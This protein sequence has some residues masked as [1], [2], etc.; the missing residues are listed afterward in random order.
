LRVYGD[1]AR[2]FAL[3]E[4]MAHHLSAAGLGSASEIFDGDAPFVPRG[5]IAQAWSVG[6]ILRAWQACYEA[7]LKIEDTL[8]G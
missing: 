6:E 2:A 1:P 8:K 5:A 7:G 4:P 3:L